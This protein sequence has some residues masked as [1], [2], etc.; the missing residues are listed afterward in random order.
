MKLTDCFY[1]PGAKNP[2]VH[3][4]P[5]GHLHVTRAA[6]LGLTKLPARKAA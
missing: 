5:G 6:V 1:C 3:V 2:G 4:G